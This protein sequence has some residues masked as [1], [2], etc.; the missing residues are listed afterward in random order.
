ME[1]INTKV[2]KWGN[3]LGV[4]IPKKVVDNEK[5][6][7]NSEISITIQSI[8]K[9]KVKDIFGTLKN[10]RINTQKFKD[11]IRKEESDE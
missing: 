6:E 4:I 2:K 8:K 10:W 1:Q 3:S 9:T 11:E 5:I 7:E